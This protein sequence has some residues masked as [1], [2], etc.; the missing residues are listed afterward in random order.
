MTWNAIFVLAGYGLGESWALVESYAPAL[1]W[2]VVV[3]AVGAVTTFVALRLRS[4]A[5]TE[6]E[7]T[8]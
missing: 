3:G 5:R 2:T 8:R 4:G 1:Q 7:S 6:R